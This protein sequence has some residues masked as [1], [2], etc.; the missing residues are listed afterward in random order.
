MLIIVSCQLFSELSNESSDTLWQLNRRRD[1]SPANVA[2]PGA[3]DADAES[4]Q[5][6]AANDGE[7]VKVFPPSPAEHPGSG[8]TTV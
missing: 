7:N 2:L 6:S 4:P 5:T 3:A 1:W 8:V